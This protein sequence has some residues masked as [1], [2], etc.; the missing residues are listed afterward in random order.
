MSFYGRLVDRID[1]GR[2]IV[3]G[4]NVMGSRPDGWWNDREGAM[5]RLAQQV[6]EWCWTHDDEVIVVFDGPEREAV[7]ALAGGTLAIRFAGGAARRD[8]A[9]DV[10]VDLTRPGDTVV[11]ADRG[12]RRRLSAGVTTIGPRSFLDRLGR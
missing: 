4:N 12:L 8:G 7:V 6:A 1:E 10:I 9:D 11:T 3:D 2:W 5:E